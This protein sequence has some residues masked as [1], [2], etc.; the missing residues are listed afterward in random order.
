V[1]CIGGTLICQGGL[2][3]SCRSG[4]GGRWITVG[5]GMGLVYGVYGSGAESSTIAGSGEVSVA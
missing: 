3:G 4:W 1:P 2:G 5:A